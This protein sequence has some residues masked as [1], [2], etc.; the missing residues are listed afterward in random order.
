MIN[1]YMTGT[2]SPKGKTIAG[3]GR[4]FSKW[5]NNSMVGNIPSNIKITA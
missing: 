1:I 4:N 5:Q 3:S 2:F